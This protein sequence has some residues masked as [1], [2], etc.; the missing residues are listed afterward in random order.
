MTFQFDIGVFA[1]NESRTIRSCVGALDRAC[2]GHTARISVLL[3]GITD[4]STQILKSLKL[5]HASLEVYLFPEADKATAINE[6][7]Y[8]IRDCAAKVHF[9]SM[10]ML[11]S[12]PVPCG[13]WRT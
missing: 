9:L 12:R 3:N 8:S 1:V 2:E 11:R 6:F 5:L 10:A 13:P 7:L 4:N